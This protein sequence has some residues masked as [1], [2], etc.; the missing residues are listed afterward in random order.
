MYQ[1]TC[2]ILTNK[3]TKENRNKIRLKLIFVAILQ[4]GA[5]PENMIAY[6]FKTNFGN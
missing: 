1:I 6:E 4:N 3:K 2:K 5:K